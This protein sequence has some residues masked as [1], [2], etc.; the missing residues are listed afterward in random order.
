[1]LP[2]VFV[3]RAV[4]QAPFSLSHWLY[5]KENR[6]PF[7]PLLIIFV[8]FLCGEKNGETTATREQSVNTHA[9]EENRNT[10]FSPVTVELH[11]CSPSP[12]Q[13]ARNAACIVH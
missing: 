12:V 10:L 9:Q 1:M 3:F 6:L 11:S 7:L 2:G 4:K 13:V 5:T 8:V